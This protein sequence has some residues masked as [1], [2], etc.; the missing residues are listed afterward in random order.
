[1]GWVYGDGGE[2]MFGM[3]G[4]EWDLALVIMLVWCFMP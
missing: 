2:R 4:K 1:M 3:E